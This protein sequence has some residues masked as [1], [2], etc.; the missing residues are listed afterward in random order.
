MSL[1]KK[2]RF[3]SCPTTSILLIRHKSRP[4]AENVLGKRIAFTTLE[5]ALLVEMVI[6]HV[7]RQSGSETG[8]CGVDAVDDLFHLW[9]LVQTQRQSPTCRLDVLFTVRNEEFSDVDAIDAS[10]DRHVIASADG[11]TVRDGL[12]GDERF[13][14]SFYFVHALKKLS[15]STPAQ[16]RIRY[17]NLAA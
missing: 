2:N 13:H 12:A 3:R 11:M 14:V 5:H 17:N 16:H 7:A 9:P 4:S 15:P 1:E 10:R 6:A 8:M